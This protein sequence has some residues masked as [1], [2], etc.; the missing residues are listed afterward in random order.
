MNWLQK[1][2]QSVSIDASEQQVLDFVRKVC[3]A[4]PQLSGF[5]SPKEDARHLI[6]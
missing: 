6:K 3:F 5:G 4:I 2:A 1:I